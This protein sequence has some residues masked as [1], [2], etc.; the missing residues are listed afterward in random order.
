MP[1]YYI[2]STGTGNGSTEETAA[3]SFP[4]ISNNTVYLIDSNG[5]LEIASTIYLTNKINVTIGSYGAGGAASIN[6]N[7]IS[8]FTTTGNC[9]NLFIHDLILNSIGNA[10]TISF[11]SNISNVVLQN[12]YSTKSITSENSSHINFH[13]GYQYTDVA[14]SD[15]TLDKGY[16]GIFA[17]VSTANI[18]NNNWII[19]TLTA[20]NLT[21]QVIRLSTEPTN[22]AF[23]SSTFNNININSVRITN[24]YGGIKVLSAD[25]T[26][27]WNPPSHGNNLVIYNCTLY[28]SPQIP[29]NNIEGSIVVTGMSNVVISN[30][31]VVNVGTQGALISLVACNNAIVECN[32]CERAFATNALNWQGYYIDACGLFVDQGVQN[33]IFRRNI[34]VDCPGHNK[35]SN[36][37]MSAPD[38]GG[39]IRFWNAGYNKIYSNILINS[40]F[41]F[42]YGHSAEIGNE[43]MHNLILDCSSAGIEKYNDQTLAG[44]L[45]F[46]NN[47]VVNSANLL[48][49]TGNANCTIITSNLYSNIS[50]AGIVL[51]DDGIPIRLTSNS[52]CRNSGNNL[53]ELL[54]DYNGLP[55]Y[56]PPNIGPFSD[57]RG[58]AD[59]IGI[60]G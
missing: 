22:N 53:F 44:N 55:Y 58:I 21:H 34:V 52:V 3:N 1:D 26:Y 7:G 16:R 38:A 59:K 32:Y 46:K 23:H 35:E 12:I 56:S 51:N 17:P 37:A 11:V 39:G 36:S 47:I 57:V 45:L 54:E 2:S 33:S 18:S 9:A 48:V 14:I 60:L 15:V 6:I 42:F 30:N 24:S 25:A 4:I 20:S 5:I 10:H 41:G 28:N 40:K 13:G 19:S 50:D 49:Y 29:T 43:V 31:V 8:L 27:A